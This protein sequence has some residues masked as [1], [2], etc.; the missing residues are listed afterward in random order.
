MKETPILFNAPMVRAIIEGRKTQTRRV[1]GKEV[2]AMYGLNADKITAIHSSDED[3]N[4]CYSK[5]DSRLSE[6]G[7]HGGQRW[8]DL[9][10]N[11]VCRI[12]AE[13][14]RGLVSVER[15]QQRKGIPVRFSLSPEQK[16]NQNDPQVSLHGVSRNASNQCASS[17]SSR[18]E[19]EE[20]PSYQFGLGNSGRELGG[21]SNSRERNKR[22]K[23]PCV[24]ADRRGEIICAMGNLKG[25]VQPKEGC[26]MPW[27]VPSCNL[28]DCKWIVGQRLWVSET[29]QDTSKDDPNHPLVYRATWRDEQP[30]DGGWRPSIFMPRWASRITLEIT[31]VRVERVQDIT[32]ED[33]K[34]EGSERQ[35]AYDD[36]DLMYE[37]YSGEDLGA[38]PGYF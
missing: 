37:S 9:L 1:V 12:W 26:Q 2:I 6:F 19:Q 20:Q 24:E 15:S 3:I 35:A 8:P 30:P 16:S 23:A 10:Q 17:S 4:E 31:D 34:A 28:G 29:W 11:Q 5:A 18:R 13:G 33:A 21:Q 7:L 25:S 36:P 14:H 22:R 32:E 38:G 27:D